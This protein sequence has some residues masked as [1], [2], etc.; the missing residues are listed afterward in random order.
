V[1]QNDEVEMLWYQAVIPCCE[2]AVLAWRWRIVVPL[3]RLHFYQTWPWEG[4]NVTTNKWT[5]KLVHGLVI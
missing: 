5:L 3:K 4:D 2:V 1:I